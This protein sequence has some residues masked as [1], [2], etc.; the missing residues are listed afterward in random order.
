MN[1]K[2]KLAVSTDDLRKSRRLYQ[3]HHIFI[4]LKWGHHLHISNQLSQTTC[5][6]MRIMQE[7]SLI[8][9]LQYI[10]L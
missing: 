2:V 5:P 9:I 7:I 8:N 10:T 3:W 1:S 4:R 6:K